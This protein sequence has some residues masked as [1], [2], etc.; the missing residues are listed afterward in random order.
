M[1][2]AEHAP[3]ASRP[4]RRYGVLLDALYNEYASALVTAFEHEALE[5]DVDLFCFA[6]GAL[7]SL[8]G[9]EMSRNRCY[10]LVSPRALDAVV[11]LSLN[12][13]TEVVETF[14]KGFPGLPMVTLGQVVPGIPAVAADNA[15]GMRDAVVHLISGHGRR[16]IAFLRGPAENEE[17]QTRFQAYRDAHRDF[18]LSY[19]RRLVAFGD[20]AF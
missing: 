1:T 6:G 9:H 7:H 17:A 10:R 2:S 11:A 15:A 3:S 14:L 13:S 18:G 8:A 19:D 5:R 12:G 4:R 16:R 20:F